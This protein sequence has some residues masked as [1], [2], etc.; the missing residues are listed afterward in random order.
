MVGAET[1]G[2]EEGA[3][4]EGNETCSSFSTTLWA[5][6][7]PRSCLVEARDWLESFKVTLN[8]SSRSEVL[9]VGGEEEEEESELVFNST[10]RP[11][12]TSTHHTAFSSIFLIALFS[13]CRSYLT[14]LFIRRPS[15]EHFC[16]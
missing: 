13:T 7:R 14:H 6:E 8:I 9:A 11:S 4:T 5:S 16:R 3:G 1:R 15:C 2:E 12:L 10:D